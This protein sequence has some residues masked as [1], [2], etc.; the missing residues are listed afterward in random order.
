MTGWGRGSTAM[1]PDLEP[2]RSMR[3]CCSGVVVMTWDADFEPG[4]KALWL[5]AVAVFAGVVVREKGSGDSAVD[6][7]DAVVAAGCCGAVRGALAFSAR[8]GRWMQPAW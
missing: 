5:T 6:L 2:G 1:T 8:P 7:P 4:R 3:C